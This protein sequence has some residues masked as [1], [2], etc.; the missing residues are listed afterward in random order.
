[1]QLRPRLLSR[2]LHTCGLTREGNAVCWGDDGYG[3]AYPEQPSGEYT[4]ITAGERHTC[5]LKSDGLVTCWGDDTYAQS[6]APTI[7]FE[8]ISA[9]GYTTCGLKSDGH[10]A[11]W[12][13]TA[14][15]LTLALP[16]TQN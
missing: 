4:Q 13:G 12:G 10:M 11:C 7:P 15:N 2:L 5:A 16:F 6:I 8:Q 9:G 14:R 1:M 3:Q